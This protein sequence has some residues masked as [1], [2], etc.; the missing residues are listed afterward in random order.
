MSAFSDFGDNGY[1]GS[2]A[3]RVL[4]WKRAI[5][6]GWGIP[7]GTAQPLDP[8]SNILF[9]RFND[10]TFATSVSEWLWYD[11]TTGKSEINLGPT[12]TTSPGYTRA[13]F[14]PI[15]NSALQNSVD[16]G[17][18][19]IK[20]SA[21]KGVT[22]TSIGVSDNFKAPIFQPFAYGVGGWWDGTY[23]Q[24]QTSSNITYYTTNGTSYSASSNNFN[25]QPALNGQNYSAYSGY[26]FSG[27]SASNY[28]YRTSAFGSDTLISGYTL[29][30]MSQNGRYIIR[31]N[32]STGYS[33]YSNDGGASWNSFTNNFY[34][35]TSTAMGSWLATDEGNFYFLTTTGIMLKYDFSISKWVSFYSFANGGLGTGGIGITCYGGSGGS[36]GYIYA[37]YNPYGGNSNKLIV[38]KPVDF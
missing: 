37:E 10:P 6:S 33:E 21:D 22:W 35:G 2:S 3:G 31:V 26:Y 13:Y 19:V 4:R 27:T 32:Y 9:Q 29:R 7:V 30:S 5:G 14:I 28:K 15:N 25:S 34:S 16:A 18:T 38:D 23:A 12:H 24:I 20:Y 1:I 11:N 36:S 17:S 8:Y